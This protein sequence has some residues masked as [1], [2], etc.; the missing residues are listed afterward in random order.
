MSW[1]SVC[2]GVWWMLRAVDFIS[3][4]YAMNVLTHA[5]TGDGHAKRCVLCAIVHLALGFYLLLGA[6][7][8]VNMTYRAQ[9]TSGSQAD[10]ENQ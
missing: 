9:P 10:A 2:F 7:Q 4:Y 8:L 3:E 1:A 5:A 6:P